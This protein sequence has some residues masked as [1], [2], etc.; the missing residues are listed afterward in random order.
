MSVP[1]NESPFP[2]DKS[3][4]AK[5]KFG[6]HKLNDGLMDLPSDL[7]YYVIENFLM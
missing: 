2:P 6:Q 1:A 4:R 5:F 3:D 7:I